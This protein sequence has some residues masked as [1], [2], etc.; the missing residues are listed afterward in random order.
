MCLLLGPPH[1]GRFFFLAQNPTSAETK[2]THARCV[3]LRSTKLELG[4]LDYYF[5]FRRRKPAQSISSPPKRNR[6]QPRRR[7]NTRE[8]KSTC[9]CIY[10]QQKLQIMSKFGAMVMGPAGAGKVWACLF[11]LLWLCLLCALTP[12]HKG[13]ERKGAGCSLMLVA[14]ADACNPSCRHGNPSDPPPGSAVFLR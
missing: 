2:V 10:S 12:D 4:P 8:A 14:G 7:D 6:R 13:R 1:S 11:C 9:A 3:K 5:F